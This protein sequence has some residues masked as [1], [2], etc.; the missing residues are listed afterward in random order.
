MTRARRSGLV[1][2]GLLLG[3]GAAFA[4]AQSRRA[5]PFGVPIHRVP[6]FAVPDFALVD[7]RNQPLRRADLL[8]Q[9]WV[10]DFV[11]MECGETCSLVSRHMLDVLNKSDPRVRFVS[12]SIGPADSPKDLARFE[13]R[14]PSTNGRWQLLAADPPTFPALAAGMGLVKS[15]AGVRDG[16]LILFPAFYLID[17][18]GRVRGVYDGLGIEG[19]KRLTSDLAALLA[20]E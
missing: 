7:Q 15:E 18:R 11:F 6:P 3:L 16:S 19:P 14:F 20:D 8:G 12:F 10:A 5:P 1:T 9:V 17:R 13:R 2:L 4:V